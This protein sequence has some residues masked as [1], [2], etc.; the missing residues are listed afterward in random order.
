LYARDTAN[1]SAESHISSSFSKRLYA[2][3]HLRIIRSFV[4]SGALLEIGAGAGYFL[5]EARKIGF[6]PHGLEF[7][8][9][10]ANHIRNQLKIPCLES[11]LSTS[12]FEGQK[13]DLVYHCDVI[14]HF[15]NPILEFRTMNEIM[16]DDSFLIFETG[17]LAEVD[18]AYYKYIERFQYP[19]HLFFFSVENLRKLLDITG[20]N[21]LRIYRYSIVPQLMLSQILAG[22]RRLLFKANGVKKTT[23]DIRQLHWD[24]TLKT[25]VRKLY[26]YFI[27]F[28]RYKIGNIVPKESRPQ[29]II[30]IAQKRRT[31]S[32][33]N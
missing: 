21:V 28:L 29:T 18:Q 2:R 23:E 19:D 26:Q 25:I 15:F 7:N 16:R 33:L 31:S 8:P 17:N 30:V 13:F 12:I 9:I 3:H 10:Q 11:P 22:V 4:K 24:S 20:F 1:I 6:Y 5:D 32:Q 27:Y 14:S